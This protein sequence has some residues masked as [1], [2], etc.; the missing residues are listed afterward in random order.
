MIILFFMILV[1]I[2]AVCI[3]SVYT[4]IKTIYRIHFIDKFKYEESAKE[5]ADIG[6]NRA[7]D[8]WFKR[9]YDDRFSKL[10]LRH[11][12]RCLKPKNSKEK[13]ED[14]YRLYHNVRR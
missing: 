11:F 4:A 8:L 7:I 9:E 1:T 10:F 13:L 5:R 12:I 3:L 6:I 2:C 14:V